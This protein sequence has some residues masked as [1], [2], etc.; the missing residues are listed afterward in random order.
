[1]AGDPDV[2]QWIAEVDSDRLMEATAGIS[3][4]VRLSGSTDERKAFDYV[5]DVMRE[6]GCDVTLHTPTCLISIPGSAR[7]SVNGDEFT[8]IT[9]AFSTSTP[10]GGLERDIVYAGSGSL[11]ELNNAGAAGK[12]ALVEGLATPQ[13]ALDATEAGVAALVCNSGE[14]IHE[15]IV[16]GVWGSPTFDTL[17]DLP[18]V[19]VLSVDDQTAQRIRE[20]LASSSVTAVVEASVDTGWRPIPILL[21]DLDV[22]DRD[23]VLF[24]GHIDSWHYGAMDNAS[25]N[26]TMIEVARILAGH[27]ESLVRGVRFAFWSGHSHGR[28]AGSTWF[29]DSYWSELRERCVAHVNVD[30]SGGNG[31][32]DLTSDNTMAE[33]YPLAKQVIARQTGQELV[34][35]R[36]GR[37]GDQ[38]FWGVGLPSMFMSVSHQPLT[39]E[40]SDQARLVSG[41]GARNGGLGWWWHTTEDT[42]DK[43]DP[44][45]LARDCKI[46]VEVVGR[47]VAQPIIP[48]DPREPVR[49]MLREVEAIAELW[50]PLPQLSED[51]APGLDRLREQLRLALDDANKLVNRLSSSSN[52]AEQMRLSRAL[53]AACKAL[54]PDHYTAR[55]PFDHDPALATSSLPNLRPPMPV[56]A[57]SELEQWAAIHGLRRAVNRVVFAVHEARQHLRSGVASG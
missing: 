41:T 40:L 36:Y 13:K 1:M 9:H 35:Q 56:E 45:L 14:H 4:W 2:G 24:S 34:Y 46:Y 52:E 19:P 49:E 28:Y 47:L 18:R 25:A 54:I 26:A 50:S 23:Y 30:S 32:T 12:I 31:A 3:R 55:G 57:M 43:I 38:S 10:E 51:D 42:L 39:G 37:A 29:V 44:M 17:A 11:A 5:A 20:K 6:I 7:L 8:C 21:A 15:M 27:R 48:L 16:S 22:T 33:N 53:V